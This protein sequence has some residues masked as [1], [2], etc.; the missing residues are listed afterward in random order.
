M[1]VISLV[2]LL[3]ILLWSISWSQNPVS[4]DYEKGQ[5]L[6][7]GNCRRCHL[8]WRAGD[9]VTANYTKFRPADFYDQGFWKDHDE[10]NIA[11][12]IKKGKGAMPPQHLS[13]DDTQ[14]IVNFM[15]KKFKNKL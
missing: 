15:I 1:K 6:F 2:I 13:L 8:D 12:V 4:D 11:E 3:S 5:A 10:R 9:P 14:A 7:N